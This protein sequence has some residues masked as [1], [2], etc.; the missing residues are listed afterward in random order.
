MLCSM[1]CRA[2][3]GHVHQRNGGMGL[4][5]HLIRHLT[6]RNAGLF[7]L[8][9]APSGASRVRIEVVFFF[10]GESSE[11]KRNQGNVLALEVC[12]CMR[13]EPVPQIRRPY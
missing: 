13:L 10:S 3:Q 8:A 12:T 4:T 1:L 11:T 5:L 9:C 7:K 2:L 6:P